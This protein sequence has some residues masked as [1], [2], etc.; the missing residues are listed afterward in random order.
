MTIEEMKQRKIELGYSYQQISSLSGVPLSTVQKIFRGATRA[1]RYETLCALERIFQKKEAAC[2]HE[3]AS[4]NIKNDDTTYTADIVHIDT[5]PASGHTRTAL[6]GGRRTCTL[7]DYYSLP[8]DQ[9][10]ELIDGVIYEMAAPSSIHQLIAGAIHTRLL[11]HVMTHSGSCLPII[12]PIDVQLDCDDK[13]MLQPDIA[14]VCDRSKITSRC[15]YGAP[16]FIIEILSPATRKKDTVIKLNKYLN[17][18]VREYWLIDPDKKTILVYDL[19]HDALITIYTFH[20][21]IPVTIWHG[22]CIIN[23]QEI[24]E[25]IRFLY[26]QSE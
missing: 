8:D 14:I 23:F 12:S 16:D 17:A 22:T 4:Y 13:T 6:A 11:N 1:P 2:I 25:T 15:I 26:E 3:T 18:G 7:K 21:Q 19:E 20:D 24:Y 9:R 5:D 10:A